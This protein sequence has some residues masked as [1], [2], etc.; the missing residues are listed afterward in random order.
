MAEKVG[1]PTGSP[2]EACWSKIRR[3]RNLL[4][5]CCR[6][7]RRRAGNKTNQEG[8][9]GENKTESTAEGEKGEFGK[10]KSEKKR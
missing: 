6:G 5:S 4:S 7:W 3:F 2:S 8:R 10:K 1:K 9:V